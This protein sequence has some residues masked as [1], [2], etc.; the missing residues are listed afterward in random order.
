MIFDYTDIPHSIY[1]LNSWCI[2]ELLP[3]F[4][5]HESCCYEHSCTSWWPTLQ[6]FESLSWLC[7]WPDECTCNNRPLLGSPSTAFFTLYFFKEMSLPSLLLSL[8]PNSLWLQFS[9]Y[10]TLVLLFFALI[11][12][13]SIPSSRSL[14]KAL[15]LKA[16]HPH[17]EPTTSLPSVFCPGY[18]IDSPCIL[19]HS[20]L[21]P[22]PIY[23]GSPYI[24][25]CYLMPMSSFI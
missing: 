20:Y 21:H 22:I 15:T 10:L 2:F 1:P 9:T 19:T 24:S 16:W 8:P 17:P 6:A 12:M 14:T 3:L 7:S 11:F 23:Q 25:L 13:V 18:W 5:Y 4:S